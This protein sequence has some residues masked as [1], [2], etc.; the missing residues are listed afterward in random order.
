M[1]LQDISLLA[2]EK[3]TLGYSNLPS[4]KIQSFQAL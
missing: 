4:R 3:R 2:C 1:G